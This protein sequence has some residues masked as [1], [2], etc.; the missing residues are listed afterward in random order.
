MIEAHSPAKNVAGV[1][2]DDADYQTGCLIVNADDWGRD[3]ET[4]ESTLD[5]W[6]QGT[7][8]SVS[9]M[10]FMSDSERAAETARARGVDAG[11]HLNLTTPFSAGNATSRLCDHQQRLTRFLL[12][13]PGSKSVYQPILQD[14]FEYV[15][16]A[17]LDEYCRLYGKE[18]ERIDGHHH[19]HLCANV[20]F[21]R[22]LPKG[23]VARRNF[24][25]RPGE[26][27]WANRLYRNLQDRILRRRHR[28]VD[29]LFNLAPVNVPGRLESIVSLAAK[30]SV[31][32]LE[33]H[34]VLP[35]EYRF[36]REGDILQVT[37]QC[38]IAAGFAMRSL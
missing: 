24:T 29:Y 36:L 22:L 28:I 10:V 14:L 30:G 11:L 4:T 13:S 16:R 17:Q 2:Q 9:A 12:F 18:P 23:T 15:V 26:K 25:F 5:C 35:E 3:F 19:M 20:V 38:R 7:V 31:V 1:R 34:P 27:S 6:T 37:R 32:E 33:T 21:G 8:S